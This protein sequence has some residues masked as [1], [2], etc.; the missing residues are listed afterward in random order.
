M[1]EPGEDVVGAK[2]VKEHLRE[3][4][5]TVLPPLCGMVSLILNLACFLRVPQ[6]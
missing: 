2:I 1:R 6:P 5:A 4:M 3:E